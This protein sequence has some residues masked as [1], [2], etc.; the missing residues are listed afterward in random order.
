MEK[1]VLVP[2]MIDEI[3]ES[4]PEARRNC[5]VCG[6]PIIDGCDCESMQTQRP[7][8]PV[9]QDWVQ[10]LPIMQ[11]TVLITAIRGPDGIAKYAAVKLL[12][13]WLRRCVL[14]SALDGRVLMT[15]HEPGGGS[16]TGQ[17]LDYI[18]MENV[19]PTPWEE[20][21]DDVVSRYLRE[22]DAMPH[23]FHLHLMHAAEILGYKHED[24]RIRVWW[25]HVYHRLVNDAHL[26]PETE[27]EMDERL[28]DTRE[29]WLKRA[30]RA[31]AA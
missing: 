30:D 13:R 27:A 10:T 5:R 8:R 1:R 14:L 3:L 23:H 16:F 4:N 2:P 29:G 15:P 18:P 28:G 21:M 26:H 11:Q 25:R 22:V 20:L 31:T 24:D 6:G 17:S 12:L 19:A 9:L 7:K